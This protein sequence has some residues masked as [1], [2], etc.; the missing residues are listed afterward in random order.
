MLIYG[1]TAKELA[2]Q[3][4]D[5]WFLFALLSA[6]LYFLISVVRPAQSQFT[7][8]EGTTEKQWSVLTADVV[9]YFKITPI[10]S[11]RNINCPD[12][13]DSKWID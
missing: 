4:K 5:K 9:R 1:A 12:L 10:S 13:L 11:L 6:G 3:Q 8:R 2:W 7:D